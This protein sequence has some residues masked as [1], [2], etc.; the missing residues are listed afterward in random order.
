MRIVIVS[1]LLLLAA[2][3]ALPSILAVFSGSHTL[4]H[5]NSTSLNCFSCHDYVGEE[6][7]ATGES[8]TVFDEHKTLA[9]NTNYTTFLALGYKYNSSVGKI[10]LNRSGNWTASDP[11]YL[12]YNG[13]AA[14][15]DQWIDNRTGAELDVTVRILS[16]ETIACVL[17]HS[18]TLFGV[19][20]THTYFT[21]AGCTDIKCHGSSGGLAYG[22]DFS[23]TL[24]SGLELS[25]GEGSPKRNVHRNW[26]VGL[27]NLSSPYKHSIRLDLT[28]ITADYMS[29]IGCHS[30]TRA[31]VN[32]TP[33][34]QWDHTNWSAPRRR[35]R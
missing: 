26:F 8:R 31:I 15:Y 5:S 10:F 21:V 12:Y 1:V 29:C 27:G 9:T 24:N 17:C 34:D 35:Y 30:A 33:A 3:Y 32:I 23:P 13:S 2:V 20:D 25:S 7:N 16:S 18:A 6:I 4:T 19:T 22:G 28:N 14:G 11:E